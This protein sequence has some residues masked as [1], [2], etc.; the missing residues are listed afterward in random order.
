MF[1]IFRLHFQK[2]MR[3]MNKIIYVI[4]LLFIA[5]L[6]AQVNTE[7]YRT[8][9]DF[10][11]LA[12]FLELS[13]TVKTGNT[14]KTEASIDGRLD[15][16]TGKTTT[17]IIFQSDYEWVNGNRSSDAGLLHI[18]NVTGLVNNLSSEAFFQINYDKKIL[19]ANRELIGAGL[20]YKLFDFE[21]GDIVIGSAYMFE[22]EN[23][24]LPN[25][26]IHKSEVSVSRWSNYISY[27]F[28][29]NSLLTIGGV[30][31]YQPMFEKFSDLRLLNENSITVLI[32]ELLS[33]SINFK[34]RHDSLP[35]DGI[36]QTDTKTD[37]GIALR[38]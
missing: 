30:V 18:R 29:M 21:D 32:T 23:Y 36:E 34:V 35:P 27:Y 38:F 13:G 37:L 31:Y 9:E 10:V 33:I 12:G 26:S 7:K 11:G 22:H 3:K 20:R 28:K 19:V 14:D 25:S 1:G 5:N 8:S 2:L 4:F 24:N 16:K 15:W 17:F 6:T